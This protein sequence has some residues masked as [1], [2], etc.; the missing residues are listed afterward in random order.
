MKIRPIDTANTTKTGIKINPIKELKEAFHSA[1]ASIFSEKN[2]RPNTNKGLKIINHQRA[3]SLIII[4]IANAIKGIINETETAN[5][6][7]KSK[8]NSIVSLVFSVCPIW[9]IRK[10]EAYKPYIGHVIQAAESIKLARVG[11]HFVAMTHLPSPCSLS[12]LI[13]LSVH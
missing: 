9:S 7:K 5:L 6:T 12:S 13:F 8:L 2:T 3:T 11:H 1:S 4:A 10:I